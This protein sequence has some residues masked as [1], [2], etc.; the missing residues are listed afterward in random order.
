M[1]KIGLKSQEPTRLGLGSQESRIGMSYQPTQVI[2]GGGTQL[3][4]TAEVVDRGVMFHFITLAQMEKM[5]IRIE[6]TETGTLGF[7][8]TTNNVGFEL[9]FSA[10]S[11]QA[12]AGE[13]VY[14]DS[15]DIVD[16]V[17]GDLL[18]EIPTGYNV[19][20]V[21][22]DG[23]DENLLEADINWRLADIQQKATGVAQFFGL[24][25][26]LPEYHAMTEAEVLEIADE[27][28]DAM[29]GFVAVPNTVHTVDA[30]G[31]EID[32]TTYMNPNKTYAD[33]GWPALWD[34]QGET[35]ALTDHPTAG[36]VIYTFNPIND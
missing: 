25:Q 36:R 4:P 16:Y 31:S 14:D 9:R 21:D 1:S 19:L 6:G 15:I 20:W 11:P 22:I 2:P 13:L 26:A 28:W 27:E 3:M 30:G 24:P 5:H 35:I 23:V 8:L 10:D 34:A 32:F 12:F 17:F 29:Y 33:Y 7:T 18:V